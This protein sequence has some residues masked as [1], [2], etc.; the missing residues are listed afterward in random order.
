MSWIYKQI[1]RVKN[2]WKSWTIWFNG[3][4]IALM[5]FW[6]DLVTNFPTIQ[7]YVSDITYKRIMGLILVINLIL[8]FKT[9]K[10]LA[11][12]TKGQ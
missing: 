4:A 6:P 5:A 8:R 11:D 1:E 9:T 10:D 7:G 3:T 12:K 2:S